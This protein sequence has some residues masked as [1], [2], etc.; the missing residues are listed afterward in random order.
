V[1]DV[2]NQF[3]AAMKT[4]ITWAMVRNAIEHLGPSSA[5]KISEHLQLCPHRTSRSLSRFYAD[6]LVDVDCSYPRLYSIAVLDSAKR[7]RSGRKKLGIE[8]E[9]TDAQK[10]EWAR[11]KAEIDR[12]KQAEQPS[13]FHCY[14]RPGIKVVSTRMFPGGVGKFLQ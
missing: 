2:G 11:R 13:D 14:G 10:A 5:K 9:P 3:G 12:E 4:R 1:A 6:A 7:K 8:D